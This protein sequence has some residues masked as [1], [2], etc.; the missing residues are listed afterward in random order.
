[1]KKIFI[2]LI[3]MFLVYITYSNFNKKNSYLLS[4]GDTYFYSDNF[5]IN[6]NDFV[7]E[8][9]RTTDVLKDIYNNKD[10]NQSIKNAI[11]KSDVIILSVGKNDVLAKLMYSEDDIFNFIDQIMID[12][13]ELFNEINSLTKEEVIVREIILDN[14]IF[15]IYFN[16]KLYELCNKY[17]FNFISK[18]EDIS[19]FI[20]NNRLI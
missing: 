3:V 6:N 15:E 10:I 13:D 1:M 16:K 9:Y 19:E 20:E 12:M 18:D 5:L 7:D 14:E 2:L 8:L 11:I 4:L 17:D